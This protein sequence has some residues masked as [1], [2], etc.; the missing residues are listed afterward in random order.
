[1]KISKGFELQGKISCDHVLKLHKYTYRQNNTGR[2]WNQYLVKRLKKIDF[3]QSEIDECVFYKGKVMYA[4]YT[5]DSILAEPDPKEINDI[6]RLIRN[7]KLD[8]T[9]ERSLEDFLGFNID[10]KYDG[11]VHFT[12]THLI[13]NILVNLYLLRKGVKTKTT[14]AR[15][16]KILKRHETS[17]NFDNSFHYRT[18]RRKLNY[19][20]RGSRSEKS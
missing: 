19:L 18:V 10:R 13:A 5:D 20:E 9:D 16:S 3:K 2:V 14:P 7:A 1:M 12:Q 11:V 4:L 15:I 8:I 6:L 17:E